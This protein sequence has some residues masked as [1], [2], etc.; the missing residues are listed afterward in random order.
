M[1]SLSNPNPEQAPS[2]QTPAEPT[3][4]EQLV[5]LLLALQKNGF[6][7]DDTLTSREAGQ[8]LK[9]TPRVVNEKARCRIIPAM[10][11]GGEL[12]FHPRTILLLGHCKQL[13]I[14]EVEALKM[15]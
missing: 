4:V 8:W 14:P 5:A 13:G 6:N 2:A 10:S 11:V 15:I 1:H 7:L 9:L 3:S 12:R